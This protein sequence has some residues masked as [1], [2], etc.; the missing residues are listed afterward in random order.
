M[1]KTV[2]LFAGAGGLS[3]GFRQTGEFEIVLAAENN[4]FA[5][6]TYKRNHPGTE[7][8]DDVR[9]I[10]YEQVRKKYGQIDLVIGGP[11]CQGFSNANRQRTTVSTNNGLVKEY[12]KAIVELKPKMFV[13]EN[14]ST[15]KAETHRLFCTNADDGLSDFYEIP[16]I[17]DEV[18]LADQ[19]S[20]VQDVSNE[21]EMS[22]KKHGQ[23]LWDDKFFHAVK[24][25]FKRFNNPGKFT[26]SVNKYASYF[27]RNSKTD[28]YCLPGGE[29]GAVYKRL[30]QKIEGFYGGITSE[31]DFKNAISDAFYLQQMYRKYDELI[32][33][34]IKVDSLD[35]NKG[36]RVKVKSYS[37]LDYI[38][39]ILD[40]EMF[41]Y[42]I[43]KG[44][45]KAVEFGVPQRR[46]RFVIIGSRIGDAPLLPVGTYT[47]YRTVRDA[48]SDLES[49]KPSKDQYQPPF[50]IEP[51]KSDMNSLVGM[52]RDS[53]KLFNH[54]NTVTGAVAQK[55]FD[56]LNEGENFHDLPDELTKTYS[57]GKRTQSTIYL[58][59]EYDK[60]S[61]TVVN[62][63]KS[64]WIH[65]A[66][67][68]AL[69]VREAARLQT[70]PDSF[71]F[72]GTKDSQYQQVGNAVPPLLARAIADDVLV[73]MEKND[74]KL[75]V[76]ND[77]L[78][79]ILLNP[80]ITQ[81]EIADKV[82]VSPMTV[83]YH[84]KKLEESNMICKDVTA[85][86]GNHW[87]V[88]GHTH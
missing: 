12:V 51:A 40:H 74:K 79:Q 62:V 75:V 16:L 26:D 54:F 9:Q 82:G 31:E 39:K 80:G 15:I 42:Q 69:S 88:T 6:Q 72:E 67:S 35:L 7:V 83:S 44:I 4:P 70:F 71:I 5:Q 2:D 38:E 43:Q 59:L 77:I 22:L 32:K 25:L 1:I 24:V 10:D 36:V 47:K 48:I 46:E 65:P 55:R 21:I 17:T 27:R 61:G 20:V 73:Y 68:R 14:V 52:L 29:I 3:L 8:F 76:A 28:K 58:K 63:R 33:N 13:M 66:V 18:I 86:R 57:D 11:P 78:F 19:R 85:G 23:Y 49:I 37:V 87:K 53:K 64:M 41:P 45:L 60:P 30:Y 34:D 50:E 84:V 81:N 56:A